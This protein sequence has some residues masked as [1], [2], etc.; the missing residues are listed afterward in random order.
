[1]PFRSERQ[2]RFMWAK[3]PDIA[4]EWAEEEKQSARPKK[5]HKSLSDKMTLGRR[6]K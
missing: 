6:R 1:M 2:R 5:K 4:E 3:H